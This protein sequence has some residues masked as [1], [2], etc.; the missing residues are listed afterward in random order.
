MTSRPVVIS[1][2]RSRTAGRLAERSS[3]EQ[4]AVPLFCA[5]DIGELTCRLKSVFRQCI[6]T[7]KSA[8]TPR[9]IIL[10]HAAN[11][12]EPWSEPIEYSILAGIA[13]PATR[14]A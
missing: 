10:R 13:A 4:D 9:G 14:L 2:G 6:I 3:V 7:Y 8:A 1:A 5:G 12:W 11:P